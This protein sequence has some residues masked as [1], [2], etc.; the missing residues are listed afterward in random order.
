MRVAVQVRAA[1]G[2]GGAAV[3]GERPSD[4]PVHRRPFAVYYP[5]EYHMPQIQVAP[6]I[7][8][9]VMKVVVKVKAELL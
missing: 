7:A 3:E 4:K 5:K 6:G 2:D 9:P 8:E 1:D